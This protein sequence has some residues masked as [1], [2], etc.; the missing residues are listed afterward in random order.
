MKNIKEKI[1]KT[2]SVHLQKI[3]CND[4]KRYQTA[5]LQIN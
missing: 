3:P 2:G 4:G 1:K 5:K